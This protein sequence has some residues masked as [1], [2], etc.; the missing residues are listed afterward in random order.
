MRYIL[1]ILLLLCTSC[2]QIGSPPQPI[3]HYLLESWHKAPI[4]FPGNTLNIDIQLINFPDYLDR[5]QIVTRNNNHSIC[6]SDSEHWAEPLQDNLTRVIRENLT[7]I[8]PGA[9]ISVSPWENA[10]AD[11]IKLKLMVNNFFGKLSDQTQ[12]DIRWT[13]N[14]ND[15]I[16]QGHFIDRQ[17]IDNSYENLVTKLN[18][19][20]NRLSLELAKKL[21]GQ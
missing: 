2:I 20:I 3:Q 4:V 10:S 12:I 13:I 19:G 15:Q 18:N 7:L 16:I 21:A 5:S 8:L 14:N 6:F 9:R 1:S 11:G 17:P